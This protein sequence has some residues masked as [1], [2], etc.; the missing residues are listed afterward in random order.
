MKIKKIKEYE[1]PMCGIRYKTKEQT[2]SCF[3]K[4]IRQSEIDIEI[5]ELIT[6]IKTLSKEYDMISVSKGNYYIQKYWNISI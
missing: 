6:K 5:Q 2:D 3:N 4:C 1:C